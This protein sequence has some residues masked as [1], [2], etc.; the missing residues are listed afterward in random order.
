MKAKREREFIE[1]FHG[2][3]ARPFSLLVDNISTPYAKQQNF[4]SIFTRED[5]SAPLDQQT[6]SSKP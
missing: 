4:A 3:F 6:I 2:D 1:P 5:I